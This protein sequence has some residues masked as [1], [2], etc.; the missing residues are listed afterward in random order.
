LHIQISRQVQYSKAYA[1]ARAIAPV[2]VVI[3]VVAIVF[4]VLARGAGL[5]AT[6]AVVMSAT[7][8]AGSAQFAAISVLTSAGTVATAVTT[9]ALLM[10]RY[11]LM[12]SAVAEKLDGG[13][14]ERF[15]LAQLVVDET[16]G[17]AFARRQFSEGRLIGAGLVL[18]VAHV[19]CTAIGAFG[20]MRVVNPTVLGLDAAFPALFVVLLKP[21]LVSGNGPAAAIFGAVTALLLTPFVPAGIPLLGAAATSLFELPARRAS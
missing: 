17:V 1:G 8:F 2:A 20:A 3:G 12:G 9:A 15:A 14:I 19:G 6:A 11:V 21:H 5:T 16:W 4:G 18:Y 13:P 10:S 7:T